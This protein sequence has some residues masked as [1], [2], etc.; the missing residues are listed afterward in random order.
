MTTL[1]ADRDSMGDP[2]KGSTKIG[3]SAAE[4]GRRSRAGRDQS[5][6]VASWAL[7]LV[8]T[9]GL[10]LS[11]AAPAGAA[12]EDAPVVQTVSFRV[13]NVNRSAVPCAVDGK[14]YQVLGR[15]FGP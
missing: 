6:R 1:L 10:A 15:I 9:V 14:T 8:L 3:G 12:S 11:W 2:A 5:A 7:A 4:S 13:Q